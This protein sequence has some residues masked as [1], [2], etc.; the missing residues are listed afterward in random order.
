MTLRLAEVVGDGAGLGEG[1]GA[2]LGEGD[3]AGV[4]EGVGEAGDGA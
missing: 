4:G 3:G 1:D 2:G